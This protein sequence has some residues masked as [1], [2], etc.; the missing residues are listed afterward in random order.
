MLQIVPGLPPAGYAAIVGFP[1]LASCKKLIFLAAFIL[2]V[3]WYHMLS[4]ESF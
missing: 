1:E 2:C 3:A 4:R